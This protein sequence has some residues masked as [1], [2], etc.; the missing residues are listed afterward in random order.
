MNLI[1]TKWKAADKNTNKDE[2]YFITRKGNKR[3]VQ[4]GKLFSLINFV[5][6]MN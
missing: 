6:L 2:K 4:R 5:R 1:G 3:A